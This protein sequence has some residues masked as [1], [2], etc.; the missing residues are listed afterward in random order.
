MQE[1][2]FPMRG[3]LGGTLDQVQ[4]MKAVVVEMA[5]AECSPSGGR[6]TLV[7]VESL[8]FVRV[9]I[10]VLRGNAYFDPLQYGHVGA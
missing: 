9:E 8:A 5:W 2:P 7:F 3:W 4:A 1:N 6:H 10:G